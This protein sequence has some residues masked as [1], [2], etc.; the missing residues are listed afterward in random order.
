MKW[1]CQLGTMTAVVVAAD[2]KAARQSAAAVFVQ[3]RHGAMDHRDDA[4]PA[5]Q[6]KVAALA[7]EVVVSEATPPPAGIV[8]PR[9]GAA[10]PVG[11]T[12]PPVMAGR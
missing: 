10:D 2:E 8:R 6:R 5:R 3:A 9:P 7:D 12:R 1:W 4:W 11:R